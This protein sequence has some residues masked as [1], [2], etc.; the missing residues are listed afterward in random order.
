MDKFVKLEAGKDYN[1]QPLHKA[2]KVAA[3]SSNTN[4]FGLYGTVLVA[5]DGEAYEIAL[6][7]INKKKVGDTVL[8][9]VKNGKTDIMGDCQLFFEIPRKLPTAPQ[10]IIDQVWGN[11][12]I[13]AY[14]NKITNNKVF[15]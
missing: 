8:L 2:F 5:Q 12:Y 9:P 6:N 13:D 4:S 1:I 7:D 14:G 10:K 3:V 11:W 15:A